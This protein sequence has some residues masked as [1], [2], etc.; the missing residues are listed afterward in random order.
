M[1]TWLRARA[2]P[3]ALLVTA[4]GGR[5]VR[6]EVERLTRLRGW[7]LA[8]SPAEADV[9]VVCGRPEAALAEA[10]ARVWDQLPRPR[11]RAEIHDPTEADRALDRIHTQL[12]NPDTGV[13]PEPHLEPDPDDDD[14]GVA[15]LPMAEGAEDRDGLT[16][17]VLHLQLG[18][19][20]S[21]WP[22]GLEVR[23]TLQGDVVQT[24]AVQVIG[25]AGQAWAGDPAAAA[26]D[27]LARLLA[28]CGAETG[29]RAAR[30]LRDDVLSDHLCGNDLRGGASAAGELAAFARRLRRSR[31]LRWATDGVG[32]LGSEH[33]SLGGDATARWLGWVAIVEGTTGPPPDPAARTRTVLAQLPDLLV[34]VELAA[35]RVLVASLDPDLDALPTD[36]ATSDTSAPDTGAPDTGAPD[37]A[38]RPVP[39]GGSP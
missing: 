6:L 8:A 7:D 38:G 35:A 21:D 22:A 30:R 27:S 26:L 2:A 19:I 12:L 13:T 11:A 4:L 25:T 3:R 39:P 29:S 31:T 10:V 16:L 17:D 36:T 15:G 18:P 33:G 32:R 5:A 9:L 23:V 14:A 28:V 24:A 34:G 20:L 37:N 1:T